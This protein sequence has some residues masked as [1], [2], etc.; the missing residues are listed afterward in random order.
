MHHI[1][2][3]EHGQ[4]LRG[5]RKGGRRAHPETWIVT[6]DR[7]QV[8][9]GSLTLGRLPVEEK[10]AGWNPVWAAILDKKVSPRRLGIGHDPFKV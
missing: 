5:S 3:P 1:T 4:L 6:S 2:C 9:P 7:N 8:W 10:S